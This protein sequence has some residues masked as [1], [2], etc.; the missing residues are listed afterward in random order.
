M[1]IAKILMQRDG[2]SREEAEEQ[3]RSVT[4]M[5]RELADEQA[6]LG[7]IEELMQSELGLEPDY[8]DEIL[9]SL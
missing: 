9:F 6:S 8:L 7:E 3:V 5:I 2:L 4:E 1:S